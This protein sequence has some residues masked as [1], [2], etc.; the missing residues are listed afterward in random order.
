MAM[1]DGQIE[2]AARLLAVLGEPSR[3]KIL[4]VLWEAPRSVGEIVEA[5]GLKQSNVSRQLGL[6]HG[7]GI[8]A[9]TPQGTRVLYEIALPVVRDLCGLVCEGAQLAAEKRINGLRDA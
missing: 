5:T 9:R 3:L 6:L 7:A 2:G 1:T 4:R 8:V